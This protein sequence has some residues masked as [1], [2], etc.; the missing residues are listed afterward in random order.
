[1]S[2]FGAVRLYVV[3]R[4]AAEVE[5]AE[6]LGLP[7]IHRAPV[8]PRGEADVP[9]AGPVVTTARREWARRDA[10]VVPL[11]PVARRRGTLG[12]ARHP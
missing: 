3:G 8:A 6:L 11:S 4:T 9:W 1:M 2:L 12:S 7:G 10:L 5:T